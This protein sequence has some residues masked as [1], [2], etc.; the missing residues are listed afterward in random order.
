ML[1]EAV[2][3]KMYGRTEAKFPLIPDPA[4]RWEWSDSRLRRFTLGDWQGGEWARILP[5]RCGEECVTPVGNLTSRMQS[6]AQ[7][8]Y[9]LSTTFYFPFYPPPH[10]YSILCFT[11]FLPRILESLVLFS[12]PEAVIHDGGGGLAYSFIAWSRQMFLK[13]GLGLASTSLCT[14]L[15]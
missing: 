9:W 1:K 8:L 11:S 3:W 2:R 14:Q 6:L 10:S 7:S 15:Q 4:T 5:E 13:T 12:I